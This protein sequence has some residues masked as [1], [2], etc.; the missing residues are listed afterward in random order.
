MV[1]LKE[2]MAHKEDEANTTVKELSEKLKMIDEEI[3]EEKVK[4]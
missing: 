1:E 3:V 4:R 2:K